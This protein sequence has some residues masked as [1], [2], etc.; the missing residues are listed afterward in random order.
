MSANDIW[1]AYDEERFVEVERKEGPVGV[2][3]L[4]RSPLD[5]ASAKWWGPKMREE[6]GIYEKCIDCDEGRQTLPGE[7]CR[8]CDIAWFAA[9]ATS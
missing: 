1:I 3:V 5:D 8:D 9:G 6:R 4:L 2:D 7:R